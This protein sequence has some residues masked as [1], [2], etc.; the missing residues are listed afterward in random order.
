M[1]RTS[2]LFSSRYPP[3]T[4]AT[5]RDCPAV[6]RG[7]RI[8]A[9]FRARYYYGR[10]RSRFTTPAYNLQRSVSDALEGR[11]TN[12]LDVYL[13]VALRACVAVKNIVVY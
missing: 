12:R 7:P 2:N 10:P 8:R 5:D 11:L 9:I 3:T 13:T 4:C 1:R 6:T